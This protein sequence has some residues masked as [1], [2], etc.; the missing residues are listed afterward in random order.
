M[1]IIGFF[2]TIIAVSTLFSAL[3]FLPAG[4]Q[5]TTFDGDKPAA[6]F[7]SQYSQTFNTAWNSTVFYGQWNAMEP[8]IFT[9]SDIAAGYLQFVWI[10]KRVKV[11]AMISD[12]VYLYFPCGSRKSKSSLVSR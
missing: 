1:R 8:N 3:I 10:A 6:T 4:A 9:A 7:N 2:P 5:V 12:G 11:V